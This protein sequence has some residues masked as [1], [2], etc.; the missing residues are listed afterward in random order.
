MPRGFGSRR[1]RRRPAPQAAALA[2]ISGRELA[3]RP[4]LDPVGELRGKHE[5]SAAENRSRSSHV[6]G[7]NLDLRERFLR[8]VGLEAPFEP[9]DDERI[10]LGLRKGIDHDPLQVECRYDRAHLVTSA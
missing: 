3:A 10:G 4:A 9:V 6:R 7:E 5:V 1:R 8:H 2:D